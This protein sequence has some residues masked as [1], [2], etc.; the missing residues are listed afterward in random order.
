MAEHTLYGKRKLC[1]TEV[2]DFTD[3]QGIGRDPLYKRFDSVYSVVEKNVEPQYRDFLAHPIYS[4]EDQILWYVREWNNAP[5]AYSDLSEED[6]IKYGVIKNKTIAAYEKVRD[7][8]VGEDKQILTGAIKFIDE[9]FMFCYD[10]KVVVVAW[11]MLPDSKKHI[12]KGAIIHDLKIQTKHKIKFI[13]GENGTLSDKLAGVVTRPDGATL[14]HIDLPIVNPKKGYVFVGWEPNPL[15]MKVN[16][17]LTFKAL[18]NEIPI[19]ED[20][21]VEKEN[22]RI[23][24]CAEDGGSLSGNTECIIEKGTNLD[25]SQIPTVIPNNGYSFS[26]WDVQPDLY[27]INEDVTFRAIFNRDNVKCNFVAGD[28][29]EIEGTNYLSLPYGTILTNE[30]I[31]IVKAKRGYKF[32]GWDITPIDYTLNDD[33]T[34]TAQYEKNNPWYSFIFNKGCWL[35]LLWLLLFLLVLFLLFWLLKDASCT[36]NV[37]D[38]IDD[39][40]HQEIVD[41]NPDPYD[42]VQPGIEDPVHDPFD[43]ENPVGIYNPDNPYLIPPT[44]PAYGDVLPPEQGVLPPVSDDDIDL[45]NP[46]IISNRLNIL[47]ENE[48]KSVGDL[49]RAFKQ[50]YPGEEY[51]VIYYDDIVKRIQILVPPQMREVLKQQIPSKLSPEFEVFVFDETLFELSYTPNDPVMSSPEKSWYLNAIKAKEAW[52][53]TRGS[54]NV[55]VAVVDNGFN[56]SHPELQSKVYKPYNVWK[57]NND[58]TANSD[59]DHGTHVAGIALAVGDNGIGISG[60]APRCK[61]M[62]VQVADNNGRM[63]LTAVLDGILYSIYQGAHVVNVSLGYTIT[64]LLNTPETIQKEF[65]NSRLKEE[66][67]LWCEVTRIASTKNV[68]LVVSAGNDNV[69]AGIDPLQRPDDIIVVSALDKDLSNLEKAGFSN[70]G[71][72]STVSAPG[73]SIYSTLGSS[74]YGSMDGTSMAAPIITG[75]IA[76]MKSLSPNITTKQI[77]CVF[78]RTSLPVNDKVP[79]LIQLNKALSVVKNANYSN[80]EVEPSTGDV[81]IKLSW[82]NYNDIDLICVEPNGQK[83][84]Y[85]N[86]RSSTGGML[87]IDMNVS[88]PDSNHPLENIYWPVNGAP[89]GTYYV[90]VNYFNKHEDPTETP[91]KVMVK[92]GNSIEEYTGMLTQVKET[93]LV[94]SFTLG[95][96]NEVDDS[97]G[98]RDSLLRKKRELEDSLTN[99]KDQLRNLN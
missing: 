16:A 48:D 7:A 11:G 46:G 42:L 73:V 86:K 97:N 77:K 89:S 47:M 12:V 64:S 52:D 24:F 82:D 85:K 9:K 78:K 14:S 99:I 38:D 13:V 4:E 65:I 94:C 84:S 69:L 67:R 34:F 96:N 62:P 91:Y 22:V 17:P 92:H 87:E 33:A 93:K 1:Y 61:F 20:V 83:I 35:K 63:S 10:D 18:Y 49:A 70:Y 5:C 40:E 56:L 30:N 50:H 95:D 66:E 81:Q 29:G 25:A 37:G 76:L 88:Y 54:E 59:C 23:T 44:D 28:H 43:I 27:A 39:G 3:F 32:I 79:G 31:P 72:Y 21:V 2:T 57:H 36:R 90:Y 19:E 71:D 80:C 60:I 15:G 26:G 55:V 68:T 75:S 53:I 98:I 58:I 41:G 6:R 45:E 8:L 74:G 51:Q